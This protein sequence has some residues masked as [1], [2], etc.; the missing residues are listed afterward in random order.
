[1]QNLTEMEQLNGTIKQLNG[2]INVQ[3]LTV[4]PY[5]QVG[6]VCN[7]CKQV[8]VVDICKH[9]YASKLVWWWGVAIKWNN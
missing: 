4:V 1:M 2:T 5:V 7:I 6:V 9:L 3:N 8:G